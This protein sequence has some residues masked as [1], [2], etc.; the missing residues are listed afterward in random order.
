MVLV[1]AC[2]ASANDTCDL[3]GWHL[4]TRS[5]DSWQE[6]YAISTHT[7]LVAQEVALSSNMWIA[8][9]STTSQQGE[10]HHTELTSCPPPSQCELQYRSFHNWFLYLPLS[11]PTSLCP[12][13]PPIPVP[14]M[15]EP[16]CKLLHQTWVSS[17]SPAWPYYLL[18]WQD[19]TH[20]EP[21]C[22]LFH[23]TWVSSCSFI[24]QASLAVLPSWVTRPHT[25]TWP[26]V[27]TP[28]SMLAMVE[29][30]VMN[31]INARLINCYIP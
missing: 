17:C 6:N 26:L 20:H 19:P 31:T 30:N 29:F 12:S 23:Q 21:Q 27:C 7:I 1:A 9:T 2:V 11:L 24:M 5:H 25:I 14:S 10:L 18:G 16:Q 13:P 8:A 3:I 15:N 22:K 28:Y 4:N